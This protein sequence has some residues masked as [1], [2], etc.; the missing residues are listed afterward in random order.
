MSDY[1]SLFLK[2]SSIFD[3]NDA[4]IFRKYENI[5]KIY[6]QLIAINKKL[7]EYI[8]FEKDD[9]QKFNIIIKLLIKL[10]EYFTVINKYNRSDIK[11]FNNKYFATI[12]L[13]ILAL[14]HIGSNNKSNINYE[15][16]E[17]IYGGYNIFKFNIKN[18]YNYISKNAKFDNQLILLKDKF[19]K[20]INKLN[21]TNNLLLITQEFNNRNL[22]NCNIEKE[23]YNVNDFIISFLLYYI[24]INDFNFINTF[25]SKIDIKNLT[26]ISNTNKEMINIETEN[27]LIHKLY[28]LI[29]TGKFNCIFDYP[30]NFILTYNILFKGKHIIYHKKIQET[31]KETDLILLNFLALF[32]KQIDKLLIKNHISL[33]IDL[34]EK[35]KIIHDY[36]LNTIRFYDFKFFCELLYC[37]YYDENTFKNFILQ[38]G[39]DINNI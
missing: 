22:K 33:N 3:N 1:N 38:Q 9:I 7:Y 32:E 11:Y 13:Y 8:N 18:L 17:I 6:N 28:N 21:D 26:N 2:L 23:N 35:I 15:T 29:E 30:D 39:A 12:N 4:Q 25:F 5:N 14:L 34:K 24:N 10:L 31:S 36:G 37:I 16:N 19:E 20:Y 27:G